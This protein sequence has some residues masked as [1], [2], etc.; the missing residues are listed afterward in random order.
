M[1]RTNA[2][3]WMGRRKV[4]RRAL[5]PLA[6]SLLV[7]VGLAVVVGVAG[8]FVLN[9]VGHTSSQT[10]HDCSPPDSPACSGQGNATS[11]L[12]PIPAVGAAVVD[13]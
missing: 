5:A 1:M 9:A 4:G 10:V 12:A 3:G 11:S 6:A 2:R 7:L 8:Y 13:R